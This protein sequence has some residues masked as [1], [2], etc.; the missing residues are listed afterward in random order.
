MIDLEIGAPMKAVES[1]IINPF[2][3]RGMITDE[4]E[5]F[6]REE[7]LTEIL[8]RLR[9]MQSSS[10]IGERR[11]GKSS[12]LH[13]LAQTGARRLGNMAYQFLYFDFQDA[14]LHTSNGFFR[15]VLRKLRLPVE[16]IADDATLTRNLIAFTDQIETVGRSGLRLILCLDEFENAFKFPEQFNEAFFDHMRGRLNRR[17]FA[18]VT[19]TQSNLYSLCEEGKLTSPFYNI[20]TVVELGEFTKE[21]TRE[22]IMF[23]RQRAVLTDDE[24]RFIESHLDGRQPLKLQIFCDWMLKNRQKR[25]SKRALIKKVRKECKHYFPGTYDLNKLRRLKRI[26]SL[27]NVKKLLEIIKSVKGL[28]S[29]SDEK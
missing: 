1:A 10:V 11:I 13:N 8:T 20:F 24:I 17:T 27:S 22:F 9:G 3:N 4:A 15:A 6:G 19:A 12:L 16:I 23:Y 14:E 5:F 28:F 29:G 21:E 18:F 25:L 26:F 7:Q 2:T